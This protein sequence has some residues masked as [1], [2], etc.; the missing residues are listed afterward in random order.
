MSI[1]L[2]L[3]THNGFQQRDKK[4]HSSQCYRGE[5]NHQKLRNI[6]LSVCP[7]I[8]LSYVNL[9]K[10]KVK[11]K[12]GRKNYDVSQI[13]LLSGH[14][15]SKTKVERTVREAKTKFCQNS[16]SLSSSISKH[17]L[18]VSRKSWR[19]LVYPTSPI[20]VYFV[21]SGSEANEL[22]TLMVRLYAG[23]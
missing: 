17:A 6:F 9:I 19:N 12:G 15:F 20:V 3:I 5:L 14:G 8:S 23:N 4:D 16:L 10:E 13:H 2:L 22:A 11:G 7:L 18:S 21:N 1:N